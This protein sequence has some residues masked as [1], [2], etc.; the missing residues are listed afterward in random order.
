LGAGAELPDA[1]GQVCRE[2]PLCGQNDVRATPSFLTPWVL[3][4]VAKPYTKQRVIL[5]GVSPD[6]ELCH[7]RRKD[8]RCGRKLQ[9]CVVP[10]ERQTPLHAERR[11]SHASHHTASSGSSTE[12][13]L[14]R[15]G[16]RLATN[17]ST[18]ATTKEHVLYGFFSRSLL[19][20]VQAGL[21]A[22]N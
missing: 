2:T 11:C 1:G 15:G 19:P 13:A 5:Y 21:N 16:H 8:S 20:A 18:T 12:A 7:R 9:M 3:L 10:C 4:H 17:N 6:A 14:E 22:N